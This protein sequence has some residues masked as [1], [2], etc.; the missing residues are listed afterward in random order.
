M[1][2]QEDNASTE[3]IQR[4]LEKAVEKALERKRKLGQYAVV[5]HEGRSVW[6]G[7]DVPW[8]DFTPHI[9]EAFGTDEGHPRG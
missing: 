1:M 9:S 6:L 5:W 2:D 8:E 4:A 7:V 3:S